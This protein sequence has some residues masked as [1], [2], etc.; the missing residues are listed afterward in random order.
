ML[1]ILQWA[2]KRVKSLDNIEI[3]NIEKLLK[4]KSATLK[5]K[6]Y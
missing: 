3:L 4:R 5:K 6:D 1:E 2:L